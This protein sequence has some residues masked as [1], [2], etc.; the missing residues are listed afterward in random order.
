MIL[1][2]YVV[3]T[4]SSICES[5]RTLA[6]SFQFLQDTIS[7]RYSTKILLNSKMN[8]SNETFEE[9]PE[10]SYNFVVYRISFVALIFFI[11]IG[12]FLI[13]ISF[14]NLC[15]S[16]DLYHNGNLELRSTWSTDRRST[17]RKIRK[18]IRKPVAESTD[19]ANTIYPSASY[20]RSSTNF[21]D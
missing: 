17:N 15:C 8:Y 6:T 21:S 12:T 1:S 19:D 4:H 2:T 11:V 18:K 10:V 20:E 14:Y 7:M 3:S 16:S 9:S 13:C 5:S